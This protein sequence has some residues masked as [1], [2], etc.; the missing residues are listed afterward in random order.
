MTVEKY[1]LPHHVL[2][3]NST[4]QSHPYPRNMATTGV[5]IEVEDQQGLESDTDS[6]LGSEAPSSTNSVASSV[7]NYQYENGRRYHAFRSG[8]YVLPN[9]DVEQD[10]L[11]LTRHNLSLLLGGELYR[12]P[13]TDPQ[14][15]LDIGTGTGQVFPLFN[16]LS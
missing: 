9:D 12:S 1:I 4:F 13:L 10:R 11:D 8:S 7:M 16:L 6:A 14:N 2:I 5:P 15:I 3:H